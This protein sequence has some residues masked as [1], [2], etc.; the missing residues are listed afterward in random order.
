M[1]AD[2]CVSVRV[3]DMCDDDATLIRFIPMQYSHMSNIIGFT[4]VLK[5]L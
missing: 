3:C 5:S 2:L 1:S 4:V